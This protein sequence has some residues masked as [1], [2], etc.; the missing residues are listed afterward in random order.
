MDKLKSE[1]RD[2]VKK[3]NQLWVSDNADKLGQFFHEDMVIVNPDLAKMG[4]GRR[5]C[6]RSYIDFASQAKTTS[7]KESD[8]E[9]KVWGNTAMVN[10]RFDISYEMEGKEYND[11]G[12]DVFIFSRDDKDGKWLAVWRMIVPAQKT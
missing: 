5:E 6:V 12:R 10:Y 8:F 7:Y 1:L 3:I 9:I 11:I 4:E 2:I